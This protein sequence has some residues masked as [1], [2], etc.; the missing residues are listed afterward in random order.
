[1]REVDRAE[2]KKWR[3]RTLF[4]DDDELGFGHPDLKLSRRVDSTASVPRV[5][6][7]CAAA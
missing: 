2:L 6:V 3:L 4:G 1:V 5:I 7:S